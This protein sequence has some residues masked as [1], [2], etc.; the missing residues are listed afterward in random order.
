MRGNTL[1]RKFSFCTYDVLCCLFKTFCYS[2][3]C[4]SLWT[5]YRKSS[6]YKLKVCYNNIMRRLIGVARWHSA[7][8]MFVTLGIRSFDELIRYAVYSCLMSVNESTN[9]LLCALANSDS[10]SVSRIRNIWFSVLYT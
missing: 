7:R 6:L 1:I 8:N 9:S 5:N 3:Y 4:S 10:A 2:L